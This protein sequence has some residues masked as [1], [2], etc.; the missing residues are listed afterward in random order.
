MYIHWSVQALED[1][2]A[3]F[4]YIGIDSVTAAS[5]L[6]D[7]IDDEL[8]RLVRFPEMGRSGRVE[9]TRELVITRT[10]YIVAYTFTSEA[11]TI[12]RLLHG[13]QLWPEEME[14]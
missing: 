2:V 6:D 7:R 14:Q 11:V 13:A 1:R 9:G 8:E 10:P 4:D 3:I 12:L 5:R